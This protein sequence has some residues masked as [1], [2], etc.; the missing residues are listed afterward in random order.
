M[1]SVSPNAGYAVPL[2]YTQLLSQHR[3]S[4]NVR[5]YI[6]RIFSRRK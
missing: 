1:G 5:E 6:T 3:I 4:A 2:R